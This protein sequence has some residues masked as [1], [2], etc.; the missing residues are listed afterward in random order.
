MADKDLPDFVSELLDN[1][2]AE[3][4]ASTLDGLGDL[5]VD[6]GASYSNRGVD[7]DPADLD[8]E[9]TE[10]AEDG[11]E[12]DAEDAS[13]PADQEPEAD[14]D[15]AGDGATGDDE[16]LESSEPESGQASEVAQ[17]RDELARLREQV[18]S[19]RVFTDLGRSVAQNGGM[20]PQ[21]KQRPQEDPAVL[22]LARILYQGGDQEAIKAQ[23]ARYDQDVQRQAMKKLRQLET[24][25]FEFGTDPEAFLEKRI[26]PRIEAALGTRIQQIESRLQ[27][28]HFLQQHADVIQSQEDVQTLTGL[29]N[30]GAPADVAVERMRDLKRLAEIDK[31]E[32]RVKRKERDNRARKQARRSQ[33]KKRGNR[34]G[35]KAPKPVTRAGEFDWDA[36]MNAFAQ[37]YEDEE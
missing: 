7:G 33:T 31:R 1:T 3:E 16:G 14:E 15:E 13:E 21:Q 2:G 20:V 18:I 32:T 22:E 5:E 30:R 26:M 6:E 19:D 9:D 23:Y 24:A 34:K 36:T 35:K 37:A 25:Q 11:D 10:D 17:L 28:G 12:E 4:V 8:W 27:W 29:M